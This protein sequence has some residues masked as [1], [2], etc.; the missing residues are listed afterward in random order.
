MNWKGTYVAITFDIY[1]EK[2]FKTLKCE[3]VIYNDA[4]FKLMIIQ[5][6]LRFFLY[7]SN[8]LSIIFF[9]YYL[10]YLH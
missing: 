1:M 3:M 6:I 9:L 10:V 7:L 2:C 8:F 5:K 4:F